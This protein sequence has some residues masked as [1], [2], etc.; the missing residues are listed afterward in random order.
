MFLIILFFRKILLI[1]F[2][3]KLIV[4]FGRNMS[5]KEDTRLFPYFDSSNGKCKNRK[6]FINHHP[7]MLRLKARLLL[8]FTF[9]L[10]VIIV[11]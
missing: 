4:W 10:N 5:W 9:I 11:Y 3:V 1:T 8:Y 6:H 2:F 7:F